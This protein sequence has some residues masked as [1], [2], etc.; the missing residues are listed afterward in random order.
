M[1]SFDLRSLRERAVSVDAEIAP[2]D[3]VWRPDDPR[4]AGP[5]RVSGRLSAAGAARF[6]W[7]GRID[8][9]VALECR[10]CLRDTTA[11]VH[12]EVH[13][14]FAEAGDPDDPDVYSIDPGARELDLRPAVRE[15][16]LL[17]AP[18]YALCRPDCKGLCPTCGTDLNAGECDCAPVT[19]A[20]WDALRKHRGDAR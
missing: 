20:Q 10:R 16:W 15:L 7:H 9:S 1:L 12:D 18:A 11:D 13:L 19:Q 5:V 4:P 17:D 2:D 6:Y 8:G 14:I 3:R